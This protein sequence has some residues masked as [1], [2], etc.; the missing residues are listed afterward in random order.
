[1]VPPPDDVRLGSSPDFQRISPDTLE[2]WRQRLS[3]DKSGALSSDD[4]DGPGRV[5]AA[6]AS[7]NTEPLHPIPDRV[8][9]EVDPTIAERVSRLG[10]NPTGTSVTELIRETLPVVRKILSHAIKHHGKL[11]GRGPDASRRR[12]R[13]GCRQ[14]PRH[15]GCGGFELGKMR[16]FCWLQRARPPTT[17]VGVPSTPP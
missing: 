12:W 1:M 14:H 5:R 15:Q 8:R 9:P 17:S 3:G 11:G 16:S 4:S 7:D 2:Q 10:P 6:E 13:R